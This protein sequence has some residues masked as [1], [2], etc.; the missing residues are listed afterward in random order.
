MI[1]K[2]SLFFMLIFFANIFGQVQVGIGTNTE[3]RTPFHPP[4]GYSYSQSIYL[5]SEINA[6]G[7]ITSIQWYYAGSG[8]MPNSQSLVIYMGA[9]AKTEFTSTTDWVAVDQLTQ[10]Y[11]GG[12]ATSET[13]GWK[14]IT[15]TTPFVYD[16]TSNLIVAVDENQED[17][18]N[19]DD[20]FHNS[21]VS[22]TR[23]IY[24]YNDYENPSPSAPPEALNITSFVPT[25][26]FGGITQACPIPMYLSAENVTTTTATLNWQPASVTPQNGSSYYLSTSNVNPTT[27]T[28]PTGSIASGTTINLSDLTPET[29]YYFWIRN[30]CETGLFSSWSSMHSF[31]TDCL[32]I[33]NFYQDFDAVETPELPSCWNKIL[34]GGTYLSP[35]AYVQSSSSQN[36]SEPNSVRL[37]SDESNLNFADIILVSP[38]LSTLSLGTYRLKF[39]AKGN[40]SLQVGTLST[41][42]ANAVFTENSL[43]SISTN[44]SFTEYVIDFSNYTGNDKYIGI[45][46]AT[47]FSNVYID[48]IIWE[49]SPSCPDVT[50]ITVPVVTTSGATI[51]WVSGNPTPTVSWEVVVGSETETNPNS[52]PV[53][54]SSATS[55]P[56]SGLADNTKYK[57]WVRTVCAAENGA[58]IG[59]V[60]FRTACLGIP[61]FNENFNQTQSPSLPECWSAIARGETLSEFY[62]IETNPYS[63]LFEEENN[64]VQIFNENSGTTADLILVSP[65]LSTLSLGTH[66]V[67]FHAKSGFTP[68]S[69]DVVT[70][71]SNTSAAQINIIDTIE[72]TEE[73]NQYVVEFSNYTGTDT[74]IGF[75]L[76]A[77]ETYS[78]IYLDNILWEPIPSCPDVTEIE[79]P[80]TTAS[81]A[82]VNWTG[83][84]AELTWDVAVS[85]TTEDPTGLAFTNFDTETAVLAGLT[86]N[87]DYLVWV[88]SVCANNDKGVWIGP[89]AFKTAC[90]AVAA[91]N[92]NFENA[93][94][95]ELP[96]CWSSIL[97]GETVPEYAYIETSPWSNMP[98][99]TTAVVLSTSS[100]TA[101]DDI[102]LVSPSVST[103]SLG[104]YR[105]KFKAKGASVLQIGTLNANTNTAV[106][107]SL[108]NVTVTEVPTVYEVQFTNYT[109]TDSFI[110]I[111]VNTEMEYQ[112]VE[113]D[114]I[115]WQ[116]I[117]ACPDANDLEKTGTTMTSVSVAWSANS[118]NS[119]QIVRGDLDATDPNSLTPITITNANHT[120]ED[121]TPATSYRIW[122]RSTCEAVIGNGEWSEPI[123]VATQCLGTDVPYVEDFESA[124]GNNLPGCTS[125]LNL[126]EA[127]STWYTSYYPGYGFENTTLTYN[128]DLFEDANSWFFTRGI[129]LVAG[130]NYTISYRYG[131][132]STDTFFYNNNLII[133]YGTDAS[134]ENMTLPVASHLDFALD[135]PVSETATITAPTTG[136]YYFGFNVTSPNN[137][138][139]MYVDDIEIDTALSNPNFDNS[140]FSCFPNPVKNILNIN[141]IETIDTVQIF[142]ILG[143]EVFKTTGNNKSMQIDMSS[144]A[145]GTYLVKIRSG[146]K[147][148]NIKVIKS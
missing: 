95:P 61:T 4:F 131:G 96:S 45:R 42:D 65:N 34:R 28:V 75:R 63:D 26:I 25:I 29:I 59:P 56:V 43:G 70:L 86:D 73:T 71:N 81:T 108:Q 36:Q 114:N 12:I 68:A 1:K 103:L 47:E 137:S 127:P 142:T 104:S 122:V 52:L 51:E 82:T 119:Y 74:L 106:F 22:G 85:A 27:T 120:F 113:I 57:V 147:V 91:F 129:N 64:A 53:V 83:S 126:A 111:R 118:A 128:G 92:E 8:L 21:P 138:Y 17:W 77:T 112:Y 58:W 80:E 146:Q 38:H 132:A 48:N 144:F 148:K 9:T 41:N 107:T 102:I 143:Q 116:P 44:S 135:T 31:K 13:A 109:G 93:A 89:I 23:S 66:R 6:A 11:N 39:F 69:V 35:Y 2:L 125:S 54:S 19:Y 7:S 87:T 130:Q 16:G 32:A 49:I 121:L 141:Y 139:Y 10:V 14:T 55:T 78:S 37:R 97:R 3:Q 105:L 24:T 5:A 94:T 133:K 140:Q 46:L 136:V 99:P 84:G 40:G 115:V 124:S 123:V 18:D 15:L 62:M 50:S 72:L 110:G 145:S 20:V 67:K 98:D 90:L 33:T 101:T 79:V 100:S 134:A 60:T 88:R 117:P 76:N 30:N